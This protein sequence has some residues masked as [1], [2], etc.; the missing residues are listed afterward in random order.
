MQHIKM[1]RCWA[2]R[3]SRFGGDKDVV[4]QA[5]SRWG[6]LLGSASKDMKADKDVVIAAL[7]AKAYMRD[8]PWESPIVENPVVEHQKGTCAE[9][10]FQNWVSEGLHQ[11]PDVK[12]AFAIATSQQL[13]VRWPLRR[14]PTPPPSD[15]W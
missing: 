15:L 7:M 1:D 5:V 4:L 11:D 2:F 8:Q 14:P 3:R 13:A 6:G 12:A 9:W 10:V